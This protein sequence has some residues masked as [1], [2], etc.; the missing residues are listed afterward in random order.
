MQQELL[1]KLRVILPRVQAQAQAQVE[2]TSIPH[3]AL[4]K[5]KSLRCIGMCQLWFSCLHGSSSRLDSS[6]VPL[7]LQIP[8]QVTVM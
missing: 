7:E 6:A 5:R 4:A 1:A 8:L 2:G 3:E